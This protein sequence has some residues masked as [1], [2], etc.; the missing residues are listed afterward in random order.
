MK[1]DS[2]LYQ[3]INNTTQILLEN[4]NDTKVSNVVKE[5]KKLL[6]DHN[7]ALKIIDKMIDSC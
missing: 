3:K 5:N 6:S 4:L 1:R 7:N 2:E